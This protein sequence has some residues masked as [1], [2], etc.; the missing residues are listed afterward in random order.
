MPSPLSHLFSPLAL[1]PVELQNRIVSTAHQTT[2]VHESLPTDDFVAYHEGRARGG[3][4]LIVLEATAVTAAGTLTSHTLAGYRPEIVPAWERVAAAVQP[5]GTKLFVQLLHSGREVI[6]SSPRPPA[7][8][9][10]PV[11][12]QR[13]HGEPRALRADEI[14]AIV[15]G[16]ARAAEL[17]AKGGLDGVEISAAHNYLVAQFLDRELN[18]RDDEWGS[19]SRFLLAVV[20]AVRDAAGRLAIGVRLTADSEASQ[21]VV[22]ELA[23]L[24]D[25]LHVALG[26]SSTYL[27]SAEIVPPPPMP[28]NAIAPHTAPFKN[29]IPL[30][31]TSRIVDP[32]AADGLIAESRAAAVGMTRA[33]IT[34]PDLPRKAREGRLGEVLR[35]IGCNACIAHYHAETPIACAQN[36]RTGRERTFDEE[37]Q[38]G[39]RRLAVVGGGPAGLAAAAEA[40]RAGNDVV[41]LERSLHLGGQMALAAAAPA[42]AE[43]ARSLLRNYERLLAEV[44]IRLET[45][46]G[47]E[48][49]QPLEPDA[50]VVA[51]GAAPDD[52]RLDFGDV[53]VER[54]WD[55][56]AGSPPEGK[57]VVLCDWGGDATGLDCAEVLAERGN[58]VTVAVASATAGEAL[59]QYARNLYLQ[60]LYRGGVEIRHHLQPLGGA[61]GRVRFA[62]VFA[63]DLTEELE[64]D[65]LVLAFGRVPVAD[66]APQLTAAGLAVEQAGDCL[67]PRGLEEAILEGTLAARRVLQRAAVDLEHPKPSRSHP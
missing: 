50:V 25:Y 37:E 43:V 8:A 54:A 21:A 49:V 34:D 59:H 62:N 6:A 38:E 1:G 10:S 26:D 35:C 15:A 53:E 13:F 23:G 56:L 31:A 20:K 63:P 41:L 40:A 52:P 9:P 60:R 4:G 28:E 44:D 66:L 47:I 14:E 33:L 2:M 39:G 7:V 17:A 27:G 58:T 45:D 48:T 3:V 36:P 32:A 51:T 5:H 65:L 61:N 18:R 67:S 19:P 22:G 12:S 11:P 46:A 30:I 16:F 24:V 29:G 64:A 55:V 57:R 42:H